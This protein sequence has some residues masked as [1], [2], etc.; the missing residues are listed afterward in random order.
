MQNPQHDANSR[1]VL[2]V[3][4]AE[5]AGGFAAADSCNKAMLISIRSQS[6]NQT[7]NENIVELPNQLG[8]PHLGGTSESTEVSV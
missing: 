3:A 5:P 1:F 6:V 8:V 2:M 4:V 7:M